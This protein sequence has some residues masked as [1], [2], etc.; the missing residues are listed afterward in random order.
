MDENTAYT[1]FNG[2]VF[3][4]FYA[5]GPVYPMGSC[6]GVDSLPN[7][8]AGTT[9]E[10]CFEDGEFKTVAEL[11]TA[12]AQPAFNVTSLVGP[13]ADQLEVMKERKCPFNLYVTEVKCGDKY[14]FG[15]YDRAWAYRGCR[16]TDDP[17][18]N[19]VNRNTE[20]LLEKAYAVTGWNYRIDHRLLT[21]TR[22]ATAEVA[23]LNHITANNPNCGGACGA[24]REMCEQLF[25]SADTVGAAIPDILL[26]VDSGNAWTSP[27]TGFAAT[28]SVMCG[29]TLWI[30]ET[31]ERQIF[32][33][34]TLAATP[35]QVEYTDDGAATWTQADVGATVAEAAVG[36]GSMYFIPNTIIGYICTDDGRVYK[37]IDGGASWA[38]QASAL[39]ASGA[40]ALNAIHFSSALVGYAVGAGDVIIGTVDGGVN[41]ATM[42]ATGSGDALTSVHVFSEQRLIV[43]TNNGVSDNPVYMSFDKTAN[44]TII[45]NGIGAITTDTGA[46]VTFMPDGLTGYLLINDVAPEGT[47][48]KSINGGEHWKALGAVANDGMSWLN[49]CRENYAF[50]V[51]EISAATSFIARVNG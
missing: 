46:C 31:T 36:G 45:D 10:F 8:Q 24:A 33:R 37:T 13:A 44:W 51:G 28:T 43:T 11:R 3:V 34:D 50:A 12:P 35:L 6:V 20:S 17:V 19:P 7:P 25:A 38:N 41:W 14:V 9:P 16:I 21:A 47:I 1:S 39:A 32:V 26:S 23:G 49:I 5:G 42:T 4:Q 2:A 30:N 15:N 22:I 18:S 27:P 29:A 48:Y 40:A